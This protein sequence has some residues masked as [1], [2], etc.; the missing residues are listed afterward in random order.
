MNDKNRSQDDKLYSQVFN[1]ATVGLCLVDLEG[2]CTHVNPKLCQIF[3]YSADEMIG[4]NYQ[5]FI[6]SEEMAAGKVIFKKLA[7]GVTERLVE[8]RRLLRAGDEPFWC[9]IIASAVK[10]ELGHVIHILGQI[11]DISERKGLESALKE[12]E[13]FNKL[14]MD[15]LPIGIA[16]NSVFP[17]VEFVYMNDKFP[18]FYQTT[19]EALENPDSFWEAVYE[20]EAFR[21]EIKARV[22]EDLESGNASRHHWDNVPITRANSETR[23]ITAYNTKIPDRNLHISTVIDVTNQVNAE[24]DIR[25]LNEKLME[26]NNRL[27]H[28]N[29]KLEKANTKLEIQIKERILAEE[30]LIRAREEAE[31]ANEAKSN[32]LANMSHE[33]RTPLNGIIGM[34]DLALMTGLDDEQQGYLMLVKKS[35]HSLL[36]IINDVLDYAKIEAAKI[37]IESKPFEIRQ[38]LAETIALFEGPAKYK[39]LHMNLYIDENVPNTLVGD[40]VRVCQVI[41]NLLGNGIKFTQ[42][43]GIDVRVTQKEQNLDVV[44]LQF[45]VSDTGIGIEEADRHRLF[46]RFTQ[47]DCSTAKQYQG[48]G[49]GLAISRRLVQMMGGELWYEARE[50]KGSVFYFTMTFGLVVKQAI[51]SIVKP[52]RKQVCM[53]YQESEKRLLIV[54]DDE[55]SSHI[56]SGVLEKKGYKIIR[57]VNG[58]QAV[59]IFQSIEVDLILMDIQMPVLDGISA[60]KEIRTFEKEKGVRTPIIALTAYARCDDKD[61]F[62]EAGM[63]DYLSKPVDVC[64]LAKTLQKHLV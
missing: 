24:K 49:L 46:Q 3:G 31:E 61:R 6:F 12:N 54:E 30:N 20:D 51:F 58:E 39:G 11:E 37:T 16:V 2:K 17:N 50:K 62:I 34:T 8:E 45:S 40:S 35:A 36:H 23:Y 18:A 55:V 15:H 13:D 43:G 56:L 26:S 22:I 57:A 25:L 19:R 32:F 47:L 44:T 52:G 28:M 41:S 64:L 27:E 1:L 21:E 53:E 10:D 48:T 63:D 60:T 38:T 33:I 29:K 59:K 42:E 5:R 14:I 7:S 4:Q 9:R